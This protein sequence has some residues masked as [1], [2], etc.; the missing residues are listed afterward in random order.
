MQCI[1]DIKYSFDD[2]NDNT[3][4]EQITFIAFKLGF[5]ER[6]FIS[7][8]S[9]EMLRSYGNFDTTK[10]IFSFYFSCEV[11]DDA[12][13]KEKLCELRK[14]R[15]LAIS[16]EANLNVRPE[17]ADQYISVLKKHTESE[18]LARLSASPRRL[19]RSARC[20]S[21]TATMS[22]EAKQ[23][24]ILVYPFVGGDRIENAAKDLTL[25]SVDEK[26]LSLEELTTL[27]QEATTGRAHILTITGED[28][29][30]L[31]PGEFLNDTLVDFWM[32]WYACNCSLCQILFSASI[33]LIDANLNCLIFFFFHKDLSEGVVAD[34][35]CS[36]FYVSLLYNSSG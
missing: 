33:K 29:D 1:G 4:A 8:E 21:S 16:L 14:N 17:N 3:A 35:L 25:S 30:R 24:I 31:E 12:D 13:F 23:K 6:Q 27:Q 36:F 32:R 22:S 20:K 19:R 7:R 34:V 2:E 5:S 26:K 10:D 15:F 28:R 9:L 18:R 11:R